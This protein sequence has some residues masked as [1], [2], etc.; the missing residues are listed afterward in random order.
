MTTLKLDAT[1]KIPRAHG[2]CTVQKL[3]L[4]PGGSPHVAADW[5]PVSVQEINNIVLNQG[6]DAMF[7][8]GRAGYTFEVLHNDI[9]ATDGATTPNATDTVTEGTTYSPAANS[10][11]V[12]DA[13]L[14]GSREYTR[15][16]TTSTFYKGSIVNGTVLRKI[17]GRSASVLGQKLISELLLTAPITITDIET[18]A[19]KVVYSIYWPR[20]GLAANNDFGLEQVASGTIAI[21]EKDSGGVTSVGPNVDWAMMFKGH[22]TG[23][24]TSGFAFTE[25]PRYAGE[26]NSAGYV[27]CR[28][29]TT[30][31]KRSCATPQVVTFTN[32]TP[33]SLKAESTIKREVFGGVGAS[34]TVAEMAL[35][36]NG[37]SIFYTHNRGQGPGWFLVFTPGI[38]ADWTQSLELQASITFDWA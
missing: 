36:D 16:E 5:E 29:P 37:N 30:Y 2:R 3:K 21:Q 33:T 35:T 11:Q 19:V 31:Y 22:G 17:Y 24:A 25:L 20:F 15:T 23:Q 8:K 14:I 18:E 10:R 28:E 4:R 1:V 27:S 13:G 7:L 38:G 26:D 34:S 12:F 9:L 6:M 32:P